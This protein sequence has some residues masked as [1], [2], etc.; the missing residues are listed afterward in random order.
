MIDLKLR[1]HRRN[2]GVVVHL[3]ISGRLSD[4]MF[5]SKF[6]TGEDDWTVGQVVRYVETYSS[7]VRKHWQNHPEQ[8]EAFTAELE[9]MR[10]VYRL[11]GAGVLD[12]QVQG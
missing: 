10:V 2:G 4:D 9:R 12:G 1:W 6:L 8:R 3:N 5:F 7:Y 11:I